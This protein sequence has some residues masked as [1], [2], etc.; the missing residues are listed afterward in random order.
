M[1]YVENILNWPDPGSQMMDITQNYSLSM[2][3][4]TFPGKAKNNRS[5]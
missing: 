1:T 5:T 2:H 3:K 4:G